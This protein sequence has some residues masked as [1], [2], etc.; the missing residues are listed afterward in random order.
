MNSKNIFPATNI[1]MLY[2]PVFNKRLIYFQ[3]V[4][5]TYKTYFLFTGRIV[6]I[7]NSDFG[8]GLCNNH[9]PKQSAIRTL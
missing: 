6:T 3:N 1:V 8:T 9:N 2:F 4:S 7:T 5:G